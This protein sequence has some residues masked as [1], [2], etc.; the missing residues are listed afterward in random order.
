M[1]MGL[2]CFLIAATAIAV[3]TAL[4]IARMDSRKGSRA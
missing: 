4:Y 1:N 2:I 3:A